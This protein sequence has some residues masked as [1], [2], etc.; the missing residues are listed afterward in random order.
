MTT[1]ELDFE[2]I[3]TVYYP[4]ISRYL[5]QRFD[6][7]EAEDLAQDVFLKISKS[8]H[9][10]GN[11]SRISTWIYTIAKNVAI[12]RMRS[13]NNINSSAANFSLEEDLCDKSQCFSNK[14]RPLEEQ[15]IRQEMSECV[16]EMIDF[17]PE[18]YRTVILLS[19]MEGLKNNEIAEFLG[20]SIDTVKIRLH[21]ARAKLKSDLLENCDFY[22]TECNSLMCER[23]TPP[24]IKKIKPFGNYKI[25]I[26]NS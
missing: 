24:S 15:V 11:H 3:Y 13:N 7:K 12:D 9:T 2:R 26:K 22:K 18:N 17:L 10:F 25:H 1:C 6:P 14:E 19:E 4:K 16:K 8:L 5:M 20:V 23:K 21:R